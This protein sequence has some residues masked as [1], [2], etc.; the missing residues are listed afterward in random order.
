M[1]TILKI[2]VLVILVV[3]II[4]ASVLI[5]RG[6]DISKFVNFS[7]IKIMT[8]IIGIALAG[9]AAMEGITPAYTYGIILF[10]IALIDLIAKI[11]PDYAYNQM[12]TGSLLIILLFYF[13]KKVVLTEENQS[14]GY[15][16]IVAT[17][18]M[19]WYFC[20]Y[21]TLSVS[22]SDKA[23]MDNETVRPNLAIL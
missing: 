20:T 18:Y 22:T 8:F 23:L 19:L 21:V 16:F 5:G 3:M 17:C 14:I 6:V 7:P 13:F 1:N 4:I 2:V 11:M 9:Y 10:V 12:A 15:I